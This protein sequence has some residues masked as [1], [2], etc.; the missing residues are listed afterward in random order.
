MHRKLTEV[1]GLTLNSEF[2]DKDLYSKIRALQFLFLH[3][4]HLGS[5]L[6]ITESKIN[7]SYY[8]VIQNQDAGL[9]GFIGRDVATNSIRY[10]I[11]DQSRIKWMR[12]E[13]FELTEEN[14]NKI[15]VMAKCKGMSDFILFMAGKQGY[16][17]TGYARSG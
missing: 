6:K 4:Y 5:A 9:V 14:F 10:L 13:G 7:K 1:N 12:A 17:F 11:K 3:T 15:G 8:Y 16:E 2:E